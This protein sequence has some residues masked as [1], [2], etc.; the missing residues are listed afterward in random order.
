MT[1]FVLLSATAVLF[2]SCNQHGENSRPER[3]SS[4]QTPAAKIIVPVFNDQTAFSYLKAQTDFGPRNPNSI[5]HQKCL[6]YLANELSRNADRVTRQDFVHHGYGGEILKLTN[7]FGTFNS[8]APDRILLLAHW[9]TRPR[10]DEEKDPAKRNQPILGANDGASG[11][12][13]LMEVASLLKQT[14]PRIGVDVLF[15]DGEDYGTSHDLESYFLGTRYFMKVKSENY[16]P[17]FAVLLDMVGYK[18][19]QIPME[20]SSATYAPEIV[21]RIWSTAE[22]LGITQFVNI[23]GEQIEDDHTPLNEGGVPAV[24]IIDFQYPYWHTTQD[25]PDKCSAESLGAVGKV[26]LHVIYAESPGAGN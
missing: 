1:K 6:E 15:V 8:S 21:E 10:S 2:A 12:A 14:P 17:R 16:R 11:V 24:D 5:G 23:P 20:Q 4:S 3:P 25:T 18:D 9:D 13:V 26:L 7:I 19:L 22:N